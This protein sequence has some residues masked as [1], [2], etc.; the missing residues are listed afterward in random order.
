MCYIKLYVIK[1]VNYYKKIFVG[2][3]NIL[4]NIVYFVKKKVK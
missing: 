2:G 4:R 1:Y 3:E